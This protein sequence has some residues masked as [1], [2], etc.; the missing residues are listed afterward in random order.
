LGG[1]VVF[2]NASFTDP[3]TN[4]SI[5]LAKNKSYGPVLG[6]GFFFKPAVDLGLTAMFLNDG[7]YNEGKLIVYRIGLTFR[8]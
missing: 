8:Y 3:T 4:E 1:A 5:T 6:F 2:S 7:F